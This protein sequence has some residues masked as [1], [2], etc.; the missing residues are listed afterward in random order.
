MAGGWPSEPKTATI[1]ICD[2]STGQK[3]VVL[4]GERPASLRF[5][6]DGRRIISNEAAVAPGTGKYRLWDASTGQQLAVLGAGRFTAYNSGPVFTP[7]GTRVVTA[8]G[9]LLRFS[10]AET[11]RQLSVAGPLG[12][13]VDRV[14]FSPDGKRIIADQVFLCDGDTGQCIA[15]LGDPKSADWFFAWS[16]RGSRLATCA[17]YPENSVRLWDARTG[18]LIRTMAGHANAVMALAFSPDEKRLASISSDQT[19]RLWDGQTGQLIAVPRGHTGRLTSMAFSPDGTRLVTASY[20]RTMRLW[21]A[22]S[23]ELVT[24]LRGHRDAAI[25]P[26]YS[27]D[28]SRLVSS[29]ADGTVRAWDMNLV[30]RNVG[31]RAHESFVYDVALRPDGAQVASAAWDGTVRLWDPQTGQQ[32]G[33]LRSDTRSCR[34]WR[35]APTVRGSQPPPATWA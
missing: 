17:K 15:A 23:G 19:A 21:D 11:G 29:S 3:Q 34:L 33:I 7:D 5:S 10:D 25:F 16:A 30:E 12:S 28:G 27:F 13:P 9:T 31:L 4:R 22:T 20:D 35:I 8:D 2:L 18:Q 24:V 32:T 1:R 26:A 6:R 14:F